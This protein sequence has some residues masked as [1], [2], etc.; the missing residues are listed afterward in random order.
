MAIVGRFKKS[1]MDLTQKSPGI[2]IVTVFD[3]CYTNIQHLVMFKM[4]PENCF[5]E[6]IH[7]I[8]E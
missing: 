1:K 2:L 6:D 7:A 4:L 3:I 8:E 5:D